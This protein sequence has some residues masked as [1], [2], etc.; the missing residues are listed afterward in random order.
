MPKTLSVI[1]LVR[2]EQDYIYKSIKSIESIADEIIIVDTGSID[3]TIEICKSFNSKIY[4]YKWADDFAD[5]RNFGL[6][7]CSKDYVIYFNADEIISE[8]DC[9]KIRK[10]LQ[11]PQE[12]A[13]T[14]TIQ[15]CLGKW[16][17][18][19]FSKLSR[20]YSKS[21]QIRM[22]PASSG[23][24]FRGN[25]FESVDDSVYNKSNCSIF[26]SDV[27]VYH[28]V[29]R[30]NP[31]KNRRVKERYYES[32]ASGDAKKQEIRKMFKYEFETKEEF[33]NQKCAIIIA[34]HNISNITRRC[35]E[36]IDRNTS[37]PYRVIVVDNG[38]DQRTRDY[39]NSIEGIDLIEMC[40]NSGVA[41][42][43][44][45]GIKKAQE[46]EDVEYICLLDNDVEVYEGWL[47]ALVRH[48]NSNENFGM[49][50]PV[51]TS[52][53][54]P[55]SMVKTS[56]VGK[57]SH[58]E[59]ISILSNRG[60]GES[61]EIKYLNRFCQVFP[62]KLIQSIGYLDESFGLIGWEDQDFC[63]RI[64]N[65]GLKLS[66]LKNVFV[67]HQGHSTCTYNSMP[68]FKL[69]QDAARKYHEKWN[70]VEFRSKG[71]SYGES[72][73]KRSKIKHPAT[74]IVVL[75]Y[76]NLSINRRF[77]NAIK[78]YTENYEL[79]VVD[80]GST[81]G[82]VEYLKSL[83]SDIIFINNRKNLGIIT[84]RNIGL[85]RANY[86]YLICLDNDQIV[87]EGWLEYLHSE[88]NNGYDFVGVEAWQVNDSYLPIKRHTH[89]VP[90]M[91]I[92]Y[93][94]A[95]GC[96]MKRKVLDDIGIYDE[97]FSPAYFEDVE[98]CFRAK[99][100][101]YKIG[102]CDRKIILHLEHSTLIKGQKDFKYTT[103]MANS[104]KAM[105]EKM[106]AKAQGKTFTE[107]YLPEKKL[108]TF[109]MALK[110]R[111]KRALASVKSIV[112]QNGHDNVR[113]VIVEDESEDMLSLDGVEGANKITHI[114]VDTG[115]VWNKATLINQLIPIIKSEYICFWDADFVFPDNFLTR[116]FNLISQLKSD[117]KY[118]QI[119]VTETADSNKKGE[120]IPA[121]T[122]WGGFYTYKTEHFLGVNGFDERFVG[123]GWEDSDFNVR[124]TH[125][126]GLTPWVIQDKG[127]VYHES[128]DDTL[129]H[130]QHM[131]SNRKRF[132]E[133]TR[134]K[135]TRVFAPTILTNKWRSEKM[136]V[137]ASKT[138]AVICNGPSLRDVNLFSL[139]DKNIDAFT[140]NMSFRQWYKNGFWSRYWGCFDYVVTDNHT[141]EFRDFIEDPNV[142]I[143][144]FFLLRKVSDSPKLTTLKFR[145]P[146]LH[147]MGSSLTDF[148][149]M[150]NTG[151]NCCQVAIHLGY[152]KI[153]LLGAD[154]NY[155]DFV[156]GAKQVG[157]KLVMEKTP[158]KNPN[159]AWDDYN[160]KGDEYNVPRASVFQ[161]PGW[162]ALADYCASHNIQVVNCSM[163]SKI[164]YF[165]KNSL[166]R[167]LT[168]Y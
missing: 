43:R 77:I 61:Q 130:M 127:L 146:D 27:T 14:F 29:F 110:A 144:K 96:L 105:V 137:D 135:V 167:E 143:E 42:A 131:N 149:D 58:D 30:G 108:V 55:Q 104:H 103:A 15:D 148:G 102:W 152:K 101:G 74:S 124:M 18:G 154:C 107:E 155:V 45:E 48:L 11:K 139:K 114:K 34:C 142:P 106:K 32:I 44:N 4:K 99:S 36:S 92:D 136:E 166:E 47:E 16:E 118:L 68:Y 53:T 88:M 8:T 82:T 41:K 63:R 25:V 112:N 134:T 64:T 17:W 98:L 24:E 100:K 73:I 67:F 46:M 86:D 35:L 28:H 138:I 49:V 91:R 133:N 156:D 20:N 84:G 39:L 140:M 168:L 60:A 93:V 78:K 111:S 62:K 56:W 7:K 157:N 151:C 19:E 37:F 129:R 50:G 40:Y 38:S 81:D 31:S 71:G 121:G 65:A 158:D 83:G 23:I 159:Y 117:T 116:Y 132:D 10:I 165:R 90:G 70:P 147:Q 95:G 120:I 57:Y 162:K 2:N 51:T 66:V 97:R 69:L 122:L 115:F 160:Q 1:Y 33:I 72:T 164:E 119:M 113:F 123:W 153:I 54:G 79:I 3:R 75:T 94:G 12:A 150:G 26:N 89:R 141:Q 13:Y 128:H 126:Y 22:F 125:A 52:A 80:N 85:K 59:I 163:Q 5:A 6:K 161:M 109:C 9:D 87:G 21:P 76:N 145:S